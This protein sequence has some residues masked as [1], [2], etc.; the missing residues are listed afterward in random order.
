MQS[1][2]QLA[3]SP[4]RLLSHHKVSA[5]Q[6]QARRPQA[7]SQPATEARQ[8]YDVLPPVQHQN[9]ERAGLHSM[10]GR[11]GWGLHPSAG[12][13]GLAGWGWN[14]A[15]Q[16]HRMQ[17]QIRYSQRQRQSRSVAAK[18]HLYRPHLPPPHPV[19]HHRRQLPVH[20]VRRLW[21]SGARCCCCYHVFARQLLLPR[22]PCAGEKDEGLGKEREAGER[23][24]LGRCPWAWVEEAGRVLLLLLL[25]LCCTRSITAAAAGLVCTEQAQAQRPTPPAAVTC[26][27]VALPQQ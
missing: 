22:L 11:R 15:V 12:T 6:L 20:A 9:W 25:L 13:A 2:L 1:F 7:P 4:T 18:P 26:V 21:R 19:P 10:V 16:R 3:Q 5:W 17:M 24:G 8:G 27:G 23:K 14:L